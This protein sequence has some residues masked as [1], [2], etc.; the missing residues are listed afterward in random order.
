VVPVPSPPARPR[1]EAIRA[2]LLADRL[3]PVV[4]HLA[5]HLRRE[6]HAG[7]VSAGQLEILGLL[8]RRPGIGTNELAAQVG[9]S[10]PSMSNALDKLEAAGLAERRREAEGDRRRVGLTVTAEGSR[11]LRAARSH[12]SAWLARRLGELPPEQLAALE[13]AVDALG[14]LSGGPPAG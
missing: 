5:R 14:A 11:A 6:A 10:P 9:I 8:E 2:G 7:A 13:A 4:L 3:R 12:R 1:A